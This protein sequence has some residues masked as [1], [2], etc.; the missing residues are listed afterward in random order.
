MHGIPLRPNNRQRVY[1]STGRDDSP[2]TAA[3]HAN[4]E[5]LC[6]RY[7][8]FRQKELYNWGYTGNQLLSPEHQVHSWNRERQE[9]RVLGRS[10]DQERRW[11]SWYLGVSQ[12]HKQQHIHSLE[13]IWTATMENWNVVR[14]Y[15]TS[16]RN[17]HDGRKSKIGIKLHLGCVYSDQWLSTLYC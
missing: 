16:L 10:V 6:G 15:T 13:C 14:Y 8:H 11:G 3:D 4:V 5:T 7:L 17:L 2:K 9:N 1:G 12:T